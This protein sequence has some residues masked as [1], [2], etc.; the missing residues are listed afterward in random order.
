MRRYRYR[1]KDYVISRS[2]LKNKEWVVETVSTGEKTHFADPKLPEFPGTKR[3][4]SYC[5]RSYGIGKKYKI[6][7][8]TKSPNFWS[9][10][11]WSCKGKKSVSKKKFYGKVKLS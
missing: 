9:R 11:L 5:A 8:D 1:G 2:P 3:G 6:L 10:Q 4:D 7:G